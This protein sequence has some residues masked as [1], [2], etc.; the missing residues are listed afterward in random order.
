MVSKVV[1]EPNS[2]D[3]LHSNGLTFRSLFDIK[4]TL[5]SQIIQDRRVYS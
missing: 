5:L 2:T 3:G 4:L 1:N